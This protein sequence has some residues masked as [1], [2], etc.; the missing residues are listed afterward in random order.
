M[1]ERVDAHHHLWR[2]NKE[3]YGWIAEEMS[4]LAKNF[5]PFDLEQQL[6]RTGIHGSVAVQARQTL[7]ETRW[8]LEIAGKSPV[9]R[10]VVG[11][12]PIAAA[13]FPEELE[14]LHGSKKLK[15][16]RH[17]IQDEPDDEF[18]LR[19]DFNRGIALLKRHSLV[20]DI[21]IYARHLPAAISFVD[22][23]PGQTFVLDHAGKP[24]IR[25]H[26]LE[27]WRGNL[28]E[29]ARRENVYCKLSG[30]ATEANWLAWEPADLQPYVDTVLEAFGP[31][32]VMVGSDWPV[33]LL[34]TTHR[35]WYATVQDFIE[36]LSVREQELI[37]GGVATKVYSLERGA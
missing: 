4:A 9:I 13:E 29:L 19:A 1:S 7:E 22:R 23:H 27:P 26:E 21:L 28:R 18:I 11:W 35:H 3:E 14:R 36:P 32:R 30:L 10:G 34:A 17:V 5:L 20:Y 25:A 37:L 16:L 8:L 33:C 2:Y 15:G 24:N 31:K 6:A 12:A